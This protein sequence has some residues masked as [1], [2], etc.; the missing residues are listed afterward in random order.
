[1]AELTY[2]A[3]IRSAR[4]AFRALG[5]R[6]TVT[7]LEHL[8]RVGGA[9]V[10][11]NHISYV[12]F[13]YGG[14]PVVQ[15]GRKPRFMAKRE[16]FDHRVSGPIMRTLRHI[17]VDRADGE[18]SLVIALEYLR[19]G[20]VVG[21]FPEATI[22]RAME[23]KALKTGAVRIAAASAVPLVPVVLWGTQRLMTKDHPRDLSR[24]VAITI[25]VGAPVPTSEDPVADTA[26]LHTAMSDLLDRAIREYPQ[27]E[28]GAWWLPARYGGSAP[29]H[30][31]ATVLDAEERA[32]RT[33][34]RAAKSA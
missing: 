33:A 29:T 34:R 24:G 17:E 15:T 11:V 19:R 12:D 25:S 31:R 5:Q 18:A 4:L 22:S 13:I 23:I 30:E 27:P 26:R 1:M 7:G 8:P 14:L 20:E 6:I 21:I 16:L 2:S 3:I 28:P 9:V 10:A 32:A